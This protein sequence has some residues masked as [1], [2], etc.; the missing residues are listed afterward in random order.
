MH[1]FILLTVRPSEDRWSPPGRTPFSC[2]LAPLRTAAEGGDTGG[3]VR[4]SCRNRFSLPSARIL[5]MSP[6]CSALL[7]EECHAHVL[8]H[9]TLTK[10]LVCLMCTYYVQKILNPPEAFI[11]GQEG[12]E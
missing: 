7:Y 11:L 6:P 2:A 1:S 4:A 12:R 5:L 3:A 10:P 9:S 8:I